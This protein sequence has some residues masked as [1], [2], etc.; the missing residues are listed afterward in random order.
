MRTRHA[1]LRGPALRATL[2]LAAAVLMVAGLEVVAAQAASAA[3]ARK[4]HPKSESR[5]ASSRPEGRSHGKPLGKVDINTA[6]LK[7][8]EVLP[9]VGTVMAQKIMAGRPYRSVQELRR[10]GVPPST[11]RGL[12]GVVT[13]GR[14]AAAAAEET[15]RAYAPPAPEKR[16]AAAAAV[17]SSEAPGAHKSPAQRTFFGI[18]IGGPRRPAPRVQPAP[19]ARGEDRGGS[20]SA[21]RAAASAR[22]P[23]AEPPAEGMVWADAGLKVYYHKGDPRF[24][25]T[26][27]GRYLW[28]DQAV[29][30]GY[31]APR[32]APRR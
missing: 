22:V 25:T 26:R 11:V 6:P 12:L 4:H 9:G 10:A 15:P 23:A 21:P 28:E 16:A 5:K 30:E 2:H 32:A 3:T 27:N 18:P 8:L 19:A 14:T 13:T 17:R 7:D 20:A 29:R 24:G 31:R 1:V